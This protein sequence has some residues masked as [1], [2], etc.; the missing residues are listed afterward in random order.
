M[1]SGRPPKDQEMKPTK[2]HEDDT[3]KPPAAP[4]PAHTEPPVHSTNGELP[5][6]APVPYPQQQVPVG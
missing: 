4:L 6:P 5:P 2:Q 1:L 3:A